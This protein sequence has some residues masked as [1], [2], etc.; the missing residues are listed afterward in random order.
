MNGNEVNTAA[1]LCFM[2]LQFRSLRGEVRF[3]MLS[4]VSSESKNYET[5]ISSSQCVTEIHGHQFPSDPDIEQER[6]TGK[7]IKGFVRRR[8]AFDAGPRTSFEAR[9][10]P[11]VGILGTVGA[12]IASKS[13]PRKPARQD[14]SRRKDI[15]GL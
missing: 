10:G 9:D 5:G 8:M 13:F 4:F 7:V 11:I 6:T 1:L 2:S 3:L 14:N 12:G 15:V